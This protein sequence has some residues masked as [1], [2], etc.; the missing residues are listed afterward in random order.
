MSLKSSVQQFS[1]AEIDSIGRTVLIWL[2]QFPGIPD[3]ISSGFIL[4]E[5]L[6]AKETCMAMSAIQGTYITETDILGRREAEFQFKI[7]YRIKP[8]AST[9]MRLEAD[10]TLN[11][12]GYW[13]TQNYPDIG[14]GINVLE[15]T[16]ETQSTIFDAYSDGFEDHQIF[17]KMVYQ[18]EQ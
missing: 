12:F 7:V 13:A 15:I 17:L 14:N 9:D 1:N 10:E 5:Q 4:Y 8:G 2:N 3:D 11:S 18:I 6:S 16:Q